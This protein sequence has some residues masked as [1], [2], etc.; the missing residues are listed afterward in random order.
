MID[1]PRLFSLE[2]NKDCKLADR[3]KCVTGNWDGVWDW[4]CSPRGRSTDELN[5]LYSSLQNLQLNSKLPDRWKWDLDAKGCFSVNR[6]SKL[7]DP[8]ILNLSNDEPVFR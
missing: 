7:I 2:N 3:W 5:D 1:F 4:R 6:L 8:L